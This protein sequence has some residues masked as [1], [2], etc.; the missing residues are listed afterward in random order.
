[1]RIWRKNEK[2]S[3]EV[4]PFYCYSAED[5]IGTLSEE[6]VRRFCDSLTYID[7]MIICEMDESESFEKNGFA[8]R[9][10]LSRKQEENYG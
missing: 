6:E 1:L 4:S 2:K 7:Q 3:E 8:I 10:I 5:I 9:K